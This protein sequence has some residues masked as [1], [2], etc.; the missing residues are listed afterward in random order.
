MLSRV[1]DGPIR[2]ET[3]E[4]SIGLR[5]VDVRWAAFITA[6]QRVSVIT[7]VL[8][9]MSTYRANGRMNFGTASRYP[10]P[11]TPL[12]TLRYVGLSMTCK[13]SV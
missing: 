11:S 4:P 2:P 5:S 13:A 1:L 12:P 10:L 9:V 3:L 7:E 8:P 6:C